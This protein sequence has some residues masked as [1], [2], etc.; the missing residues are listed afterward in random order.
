MKQAVVRIS[1]PLSTEPG[2]D[3][4][5]LIERWIVA[6]LGTRNHRPVS[7]ISLVNMYSMN[8]IKASKEQRF[9]GNSC[10]ILAFPSNQRIIL[11]RDSI[12]RLESGA[13]QVSNR[14]RSRNPI[15]IREVYL[16]LG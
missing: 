8:V 9:A 5:V 2:L 4:H 1:T 6:R 12:V 3:P 13:I 15:R 16:H 14:L 11:A 7:S 10:T